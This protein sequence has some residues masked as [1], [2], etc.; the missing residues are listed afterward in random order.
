MSLQNNISFTVNT[1]G[2][3]VFKS[4]KTSVWPIFLMVNELPYKMR[5]NRDFMILAGLWYGSDKPSMNLFFDPLMQSLTELEKG[6]EIEKHGGETVLVKAYMLSLSCDIPA[7][8]A[9][10]NMN[11]HNGEAC[12]V[13]CSQTGKNN[14][15][16]TGGNIRVFPFCVED[17]DG[18]ERSRDRMV[19]CAQ[20]AV[21][22]SKHVEGIKGPSALMFCPIFDVSKGVAI[23]YM[24]LVCLGVVRLLL[25]LWFDI[26]NSLKN[27]SMYSYLDIIDSRLENIRTPHFITRLPRSIS[28]HLKFW[29][30][31]ELRSWLFFY[32]IP[33]ILDLMKP[34]YFYHY[35]AFLE[36]VYLLCQ[37]SISP[38]DLEKSEQLLRYFVFM[39]PSLYDLRYSTINVHYLVHLPQGVRELGPLWS[40]SCFAFEGAN[41]E[42]LK[43]FHGTQ[44]I[45]LQIVNAVHVFQML[46]TLTEEITETSV[47]Y[48]FV[49]N[50][51][52]Q[53]SVIQDV[54]NFSFH[55]KPYQK[56]VSNK[57]KAL[58]AKKLGTS[59]HSLKFYKRATIRGVT[60]QSK[61]YTRVS[62]RNSYTIR[63]V[64]ND[65]IHYGFIQWFASLEESET[66]HKFACVRKLIPGDSDLLKK[67]HGT[68]LNV[69][70]PVLDNFMNITLTHLRPLKISEEESLIIL[71]NILELCIC[72]ETDDFL[73]VCQEPNHVE[74]NL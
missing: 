8:A 11:Q 28:Q 12:C 6:I 62:K 22:S 13:K 37:S 40:V 56:D 24:H 17:P 41:G 53:N 73:I 66:E 15:T 36:G 46:P 60:Y 67:N 51:V 20:I 74:K 57:A 23:D 58:I 32:S 44:F 71:N 14:R 43:L 26:G 29:K 30:A 38:R 42:L 5:S 18:P 25:R 54:L 39:L 65:K 33:C 55:G 9:V 45:D 61:D 19:E 69:S 21:N 59:S 7:R 1:D 16:E 52:K 47:A 64:D 63:F 49:N 31:A 2:I 27:W 50:L 72:I 10:L 4:S 70:P 35:C 68:G 48:K 3:P 34:A